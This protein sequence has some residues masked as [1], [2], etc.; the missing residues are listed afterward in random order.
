M[1]KSVNFKMEGEMQKRVGGQKGWYKRAAAILVIIAV[2]FWLWFGIGSAVVMQG[3]A[4]DWFMYLMMPGGIFIISALIAW[5]WSRVGGMILALEGLL[6]LVF[7]IRA[8]TIGNYDAST[9]ILMILTLCLPPLISGFLFAFHGW[10]NLR[11][12]VDEKEE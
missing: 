11:G 3:T 12:K 4:F 8:Y 9:F 1:K 7:V 2:V 10:Q 5:R 6:A